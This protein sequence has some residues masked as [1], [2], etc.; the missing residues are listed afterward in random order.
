MTLHPM[1]CARYA[2]QLV[3]SSTHY[4][5]VFVATLV[6]L[7]TPKSHAQKAPA[8]GIQSGY[9]AQPGMEVKWGFASSVVA[10]P[11]DVVLK[12]ITDFDHYAEFIPRCHR[13]KV[14]ARRGDDAMIY[15]ETRALRNTTAFWVQLRVKTV[16]SPDGKVVVEG[17]KVS[18]NV[19]QGTARWELY[20]VENGRKT[21]LAFKIIIDV[22][23]PIP[24]SLISS[25]NLQTAQRSVESVRERALTAVKNTV[26]RVKLVTPK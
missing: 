4:A 15:V 20:P 1:F 8:A 3:L 17:K 21:K 24:S 7:P 2:S 19:K 18:G 14:L 5:L 10:A 13:S 12:T 23:L 16:K 11:I 6:C 26:M 25:Q 9:I 22:D